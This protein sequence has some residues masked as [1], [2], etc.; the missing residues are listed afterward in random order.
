MIM[1]QHQLGI[2]SGL[3]TDQFTP[4]HG[5]SLISYLVLWKKSPQNL[6]TWSHYTHWFSLTV[7]VG[8]EF[9]AVVLTSVSHELVVT[10][11]LGLGSSWR[12]LW[13]HGWCWLGRLDQRELGLFLY[14]CVVPQAG[15]LAWT[16]YML[17]W[18]SQEACS[19]RKCQT[20]ATLSFITYIWKSCSITSR[21]TQ[22][23]GKGT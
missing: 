3:V 20:K 9:R 1:M 15:Y 2:R 14:L 18:G 8:Q 17:A 5:L 7:S 16:S 22:Y 13:S 6:V 11:W 23:Q 4:S 10:W 19:K 12:L 21:L